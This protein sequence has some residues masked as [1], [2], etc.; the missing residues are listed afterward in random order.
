LEGDD[1]GRDIVDFEPAEVE[2]NTADSEVD[3][4]LVL[5][6][7][8]RDRSPLRGLG[9]EGVSRE[10]ETSQ[11]NLRTLKAR[12]AFNQTVKALEIDKIVE[13]FMMVKLVT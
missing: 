5:E 4:D 9:R 3:G 6:E 13:R 1:D 10:K 8:A 7:V 11:C 2:E 12:V